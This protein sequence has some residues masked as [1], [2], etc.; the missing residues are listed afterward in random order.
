MLY[1]L[2]YHAPELGNYMNVKSTQTSCR[3]PPGDPV[4]IRIRLPCSDHERD[5]LHDS[6]DMPFRTVERQKNPGQPCANSKHNSG[7]W[8]YDSCART[9]LNNPRA[10]WNNSNAVR[11]TLRMRPIHFQPG[12]RTCPP[13][14]DNDGSCQL[15]EDGKSYVCVCAPGYEDPQCK[16]R[17]TDLR[18]CDNHGSPF[19]DDK[20]MCPSGFAGLRCEYADQCIGVRCSPGK[21][22][23]PELGMCICIGDDPTCRNTTAAAQMHN[24]GAY[25]L[26]V[27]IIVTACVMAGLTIYNRIRKWRRREHKKTAV[28]HRSTR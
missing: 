9:N 13:R 3:R 2:R 27:T 7:G 19:G 16:T 15:S 11:S 23:A 5:A 4:Y 1:L 22:C 26:V 10:F 28:R 18:P 6:R 24:K 21:M 20:C 14:C 17:R 25:L 12:V 8:W